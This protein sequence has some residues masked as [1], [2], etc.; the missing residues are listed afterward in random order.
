M[1]LGHAPPASNVS[2]APACALTTR[3]TGLLAGG[4]YAPSARRRLAWFVRPHHFPVNAEGSANRDSGRFLRQLALIALT[5]VV[6]SVLVLLL[7]R[8]SIPVPA[9]WHFWGPLVI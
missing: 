4:A 2:R 9:A 8:I 7:S 3:S 6:A 5:W 1:R